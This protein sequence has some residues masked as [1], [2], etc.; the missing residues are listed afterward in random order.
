MNTTTQFKAGSTYYGRSICDSDSITTMTVISRTR[1]TIRVKLSSRDAVKT[2]R[3][4]LYNGVEHVMPHGRYSMALSI[5][6][7]HEGTGPTTRPNRGEFSEPQSVVRMKLSREE[8]AERSQAIGVANASADGNS[9]RLADDSQ[10]VWDARFN[11]WAMTRP[12]NGT[13]TVRTLKLAGGMVD[14]STRGP[15]MYNPSA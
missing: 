5:G 15:L 11:H 12:G 13:G 9:L 1:C 7:D 14:C 6:A 4:H 2:L 10:Y 8:M 3:P